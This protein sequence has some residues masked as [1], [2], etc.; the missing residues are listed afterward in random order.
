MSGTR[1]GWLLSAGWHSAISGQNVW[2]QGVETRGGLSHGPFALGVQLSLDAP[3]ELTDR[4][5]TVRLSRGAASAFG[6][7][8]IPAGDS[9]RFALAVG[10][11]AAGFPRQSVDVSSGVTR[12]PDA[13]NVSALL[14]GEVGVSYRASWQ[15]AVWALGLRAG[16]DVVLAPPTIGY[17]I[18]G[19]FVAVHTLWTV[20]PKAVL[21][22]EVASY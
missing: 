5:A 8:A 13:W 17:D 10:A 18:G 4:Y 16:A 9:L 3:T 14:A 22:L 2:L 21:A 12:A 1:W 20:Q 19:A 15:G 6:A 7:V 11:G